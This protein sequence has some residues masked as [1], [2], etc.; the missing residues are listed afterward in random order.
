MAKKQKQKESTKTKGPDVQPAAAPPIST[1]PYPRSSPASK[2]ASVTPR[3]PTP[4]LSSP[5][6]TSPKSVSHPFE[7]EEQEAGRWQAQTTGWG[8]SPHI[9]HQ[10]D[11][12]AEDHDEEEEEADTVDGSWGNTAADGPHSPAGGANSPVVGG[13]DQP[14][15]LESHGG[16]GGN[17]VSAVTNAFG[18]GSHS[19]A[20]TRS[21]EPATAAQGGVTRKSTLKKKPP[22][23][24]EAVTDPPAPATPPTAAKRV[25]FTSY[26]SS[27]DVRSSSPPLFPIP[28]TAPPPKVNKK[29]M[30][31]RSQSQGAFARGWG[32]PDQ[33][34]PA[35]VGAW[36][37]W[38]Q[39]AMA[40][41]EAR[42]HGMTRFATTIQANVP[43]TSA[44]P[45]PAP[46][47][48]PMPASYLP[49][50]HSQPNISSLQS[51]LHNIL[52]TGAYPSAQQH[53]PAMHHRQQSL[54]T[55]MAS[56][57]WQAWGN[58]P[59]IAQTHPHA[60][61]MQPANSWGSNDWDNQEAGA[62]G[63][64]V[65]QG[66]YDDQGVGGGKA[67]D[68][69]GEGGEDAWG[70]GGGGGGYDPWGN[71]NAAAGTDSKE[72]KSHKRGRSKST[73]NVGGWGGAPARDNGWDQQDDNGWG[74]KKAASSGGHG[75]RSEW[76]AIPEEDEEDEDGY[77]DDMYTEPE[78]YDSRRRH[79]R[80]QSGISYQYQ[81]P[82]QQPTTPVWEASGTPFAGIKGTANGAV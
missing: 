36:M 50:G 67:G 2:H 33:P 71:D 42:K 82:S 21:S 43:A 23:N 22:V 3:G 31:T 28:N 75:G 78:D 30:H 12:W 62:W 72:K 65:D 44:H 37:Q 41:E 64:P 46:P 15:E 59:K 68:V 27:F 34:P 70:K 13:W 73:S 7:E 54:P 57:A 8:N 19:Q 29:P 49:R 6:F 80:R 4:G 14:Q 56:Q 45:P 79:R 74:G 18:L 26:S 58:P 24:H 76:D 69:W 17:L 1:G 51:Q 25:A 53:A 11:G 63:Q 60:P 47:S 38:G 16:W 10:G 66:G 52:G 39:E 40:N 61:Q 77:D 35:A 81:S 5:H 20:Q 9:R 55:Q 32:E 48:A